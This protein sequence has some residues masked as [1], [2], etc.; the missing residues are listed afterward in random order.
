VV[1]SGEKKVEGNRSFATRQNIIILPHTLTHVCLHNNQSGADKTWRR[2]DISIDVTQCQEDHLLFSLIPHVTLGASP[3][4]IFYMVILILFG[5]LH[6]NVL[7]VSLVL[8]S[9]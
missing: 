6:L 5:A 8:V 9:K 7:L 1:S 3:P 4:V 2:Q